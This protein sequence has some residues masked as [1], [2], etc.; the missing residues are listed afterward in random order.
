MAIRK[1]QKD[2][3]WAGLGQYLRGEGFA[4]KKDVKEIISTEVLIRKLS[5]KNDLRDF[6][7]KKDLAK[8]AT[9]DDL[10]RFAT[11]SDLEKLRYD[12]KGDMLDTLA[13]FQLGEINPK[14]AKIDSRLENLESDVRFIKRDINGIKSDPALTS[15]AFKLQTPHF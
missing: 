12:I 15:P 2:D 7:T 9:K 3:R 1:K 4:T 11:K 6:A 14:L 5:T 8:F 13:E 10:K